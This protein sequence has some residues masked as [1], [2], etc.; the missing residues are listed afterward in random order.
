MKRNTM[1]WPFALCLLLALTS[2]MHG[3]HGSG[4]RKTETRDLPAF[5]AIETSG[6]FE[7]TV[8]CQKPA[9]FAVEADDNLL[10]LVQTEVRDGVLRVTTTKGYSSNG[11]IVLR[12][13]VPDLTRVKSTGAGKFNISN[14]KNDQFEIQST[15]AATV[16][17]S[18][19]S[20]SL[21][22]GSTG[23]GKIDAHDLRASNASVKVTGAAGVDVYATDD[24][25]VTVSGA[26]RVTYSGNPKI[27]KKV[28][29]A[30]QVVKK[31]GISA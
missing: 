19:Q 23:A 29:G 12:I 31:E 15:G 11:G 2:C 30:G 10:P 17:A 25:D 5:N 18:G 27:T 3:V 28:S 21:T 9:S 20:K 1:L 14:L 24:L 22:I 13:N 26:G 8:E 6:A 16:V 7:V 4:V